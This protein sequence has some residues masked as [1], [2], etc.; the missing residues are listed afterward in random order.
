MGPFST[1]IFKGSERMIPAA[2]IFVYCVVLFDALVKAA[3][4]NPA[5][6]DPTRAT[7]MAGAKAPAVII[8]AMVIPAVIAKEVNAVFKTSFS[9]RITFP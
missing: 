4:L 8:A 9:S 2:L 7:A 1:H 6:F 5:K 3:P